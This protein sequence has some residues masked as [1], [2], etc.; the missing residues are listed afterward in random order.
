M[1]V[2]CYFAHKNQF[3]DNKTYNMPKHGVAYEL[4]KMAVV[5]PGHITHLHKSSKENKVK[6]CV[7]CNDTRFVAFDI[8]FYRYF[9][10]VTLFSISLIVFFL[11]DTT[12]KDLRLKTMMKRTNTF[13]Q[14]TRV[15]GVMFLR[16]WRK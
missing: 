14:R 11:I 2:A 15:F 5:K 16:S 3:L 13:E 7:D 9:R 4:T 12:Q 10:A 1:C 8:P 6:V